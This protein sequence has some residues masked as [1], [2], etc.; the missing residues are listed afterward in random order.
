MK[1]RGCSMVVSNVLSWQNVKDAVYV[2]NEENGSVIKFENVAAEVWNMVSEGNN[3]N[4][5]VARISLKY[6]VDNSQAQRDID[7]FIFELE[8]ENYLV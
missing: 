6:G 7:E 2:F 3:I 1:K 4:E 5:I 8:R